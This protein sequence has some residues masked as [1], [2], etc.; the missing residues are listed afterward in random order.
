MSFDEVGFLVG[1]SFLLGLA[2]LFDEAHGLAFETAVEPTPGTRVHNI[3][4]LFRGEVEEL[5]KVDTPVGEFTECALLLQL[6]VIEGQPWYFNSGR[7]RASLVIAFEDDEER[8]RESIL[9]T[10]GLLGVLFDVVSIVHP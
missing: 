1:F 9:R 2:Q 10:G 3:A 8:S 5:I 4:K 7:V 6:C